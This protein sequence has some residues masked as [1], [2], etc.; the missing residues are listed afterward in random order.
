[1]GLRFDR[2]IS[3]EHVTHDLVDHAHRRTELR[4]VVCG[5]SWPAGGHPRWRTSAGAAITSST[6]SCWN[7]GVSDC[8]AVLVSRCNNRGSTLGWIATNYISRSRADR[9]QAASDGM[10]GEEYGCPNA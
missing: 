3:E 1:L 5:T 4:V 2:L 6:W 10:G 8:M 9:R 7:L